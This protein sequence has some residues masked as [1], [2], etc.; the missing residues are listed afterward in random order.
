MLQTKS[1]GHQP[2]G[3]AEEDFKGFLQYMGV[4]AILVMW[5]PS[6]QTLVSSS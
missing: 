1:K 3:S 2:S 4:V 5:L 6:E